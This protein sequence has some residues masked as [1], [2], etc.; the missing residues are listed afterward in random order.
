M[1]NVI[2]PAAGVG[3][4]LR[5]HTHTRP[6][7]LLHVA[8]KPILGHILDRL[9]ALPDPGPVWLVI[10][11]RGDQVQDYVRSAYDLDFHFVEQTELRGLGH[12]IH[13]AL[14]EI[15][16]DDPV[17][18]ILGD[19]ILDVDLAEF[20]SGGD[21]ALG[22]KEVAD[23]RRFGVVELSADGRYVKH[24]V[25][26]PA[27]PP[28]NLAVVGLYGFH[29]TPLLRSALAEVVGGGTTTA[30]EIQMTNALQL[31]VERG[32]RMRAVRVDGWFDC[33]NFESLLDTN[34]YLLEKSPG[35][36]DRDGSVVVPPSYISPSA[37]IERSVIGPYAS[38]SDEAE[39]VDSV[40]R[41]S[42]ISEG[43]GVKQCILENSIVGTRAVVHGSVR[44]VNLGEASVVGP[45]GT[46][47]D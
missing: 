38:V 22:V 14:S 11:F 34:R 2:I 9:Q 3:T 1:T 23:P 36:G 27:N 18:V 41:N 40:I 37:R 15:P 35:T 46:E 28:S 6:K 12:A 21:D 45:L 26:K 44:Q 7:A 29:N 10:G 19:T 24:L 25:E 39:I 30:G 33:G 16:N 47:I 4:R 42:I 32:S 20:M 8:G 5:P 31:M 43:A 13:L 17:L